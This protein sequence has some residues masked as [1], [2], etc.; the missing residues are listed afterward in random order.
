[1]IRIKDHKTRYMFDPFAYLGPKRRKLIDQSWAGIFRKHILTE[2][3]VS[4]LAKHFPSQEGHPTKELYAMM[5]ALLIQQ[6]FDFTDEETVRQFAFNLEWHYA[7]DITDN[8]DA[9]AYVSLKTIWNMRERITKSGIGNIIFDKVTSKLVDEFKV[10]PDNQRLDSMH[11][12]SNMRHLGRIGIFVQSIR[13]FL[14]NLKRHHLDLFSQLET[15]LAGRYLDRK[16]EN[17]FSMVKPSESSRTLAQL[18]DDLFLLVERFKEDDKVSSMT[19]YHLLARVLREQCLVNPA[20]DS[21]Q[22][23]VMTVRAN[24]E[25]SSSSLQN[26]SDP[27]AGYDAHKGKGYQAQLAETYS[28]EAEEDGKRPLALI[29]YAEAEP[30]HHSD[31]KALK[32][33]LDQVEKQG[34]KPELLL[35]DTVYGSDDNCGFADQKNTSLVAPAIGTLKGDKKISLDMFVFADNGEVISCPAGHAPCRINHNARKERI[36]TCF[37]HDL[38]EGC[39]KGNDCPTNHAKKGRYLR[40]RHKDIR[41]LRRRAF[42][43]TA[44]FHEKYRYR[45]GIEATNSEIARRTGIKKLRIR[46]LDKVNYCVKLKASGLNI[47][48]A[49]AYRRRKGGQ[50]PGLLPPFSLM[51]AFVI[52]KEQI[53]CRIKQFLSKYMFRPVDLISQP[54]F[55]G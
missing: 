45:S 7:L 49:A 20:A 37:P 10:S 11:I 25:I 23:P 15:E 27:D 17:A 40:Y 48:R 35:A 50:N 54:A 53:F 26:P 3:P 18:A 19:S 55:A 29:T 13:K 28:T 21:D 34:Q 42:E 22:P 4:Q 52:F 31:A 9:S 32:P 51:S 6:M 38:C 39:D 1:M 47:L 12:T 8:S 14:V 46:G 43:Q 44:E 36:S 2:L 41:L 24:K 33:M 16:Q 5:G 30:A